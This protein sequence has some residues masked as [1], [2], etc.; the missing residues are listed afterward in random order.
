MLGV[1]KS[2]SAAVVVTLA[3]CSPAAAA[4]RPV[5]VPGGQASTGTFC[6]ARLPYVATTVDRTLRAV[7][8][9]ARTPAGRRS[10]RGTRLAVT[11]CS[12]GRY[13]PVRAAAVGGG[14]TRK[15]I[16]LPAGREATGDY[17]V[18]LVSRSGGGKGASV[19]VR[20]G[21]GEIVDTSVEFTVQNVNRTSVPCTTGPDDGTYVLRG[22][23][24]APRTALEPEAG[25]KAAAI[26]L[27]YHGV[28][29]AQ[30]FWSFRA[31]PG[32]DYATEQAR[33]GHASIFVDRLGMGESDGPADGNQDCAAASSDIADQLVDRLRDGGFTTGEGGGQASKRVALLGHSAGA[34]MAQT[35][36]GEFKSADALALLGFNNVLPTPL[37]TAQLAQTQAQCLTTPQ[38]GPAGRTGYGDFGLTDADFA[39]GHFVDID[40]A[41]AAATLAM[42]PREPCGQIGSYASELVAG[43]AYARSLDVPTL[44]LSGAQDAFSPGD[45]LAV[46]KGYNAANAARTTT[47]SVPGTGHALTLGRTHEQVRAEVG[48]WLSTNGF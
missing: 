12:D 37:V 16:S 30:F 26:A 42:R 41:V 34:L 13:T 18:R 4:K 8:A 22:R 7:V 28:G 48:R 24:L 9:P 2:V 31:V 36:Q 5:A 29:Y 6:G 20:V 23:L 33:D 32:Y 44:Y 17:R 25:G 45:Q 14:R 38:P 1:W 27:Y 15:G 40:P 46:Q 35:T 21:A 39:A 47:V 3:V 19:F 11:K 43:M 10:R